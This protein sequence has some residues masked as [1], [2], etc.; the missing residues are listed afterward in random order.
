MT[1]HIHEL[2]RP[3]KIY[4]TDFCDILNIEIIL[5]YYPNQ[6][7]RWCAHFDHGEIKEHKSSGALISSHGN[8]PTPQQAINNYLDQIR[9]KV[10]VLNAMG[11]D[12]REYEV[13]DS[14]VGMEG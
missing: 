10:L 5:R 7:N 3:R 4:I 6:N 2:P 11:T 9:G 13:P 14:L 1:A 8:G 12:R